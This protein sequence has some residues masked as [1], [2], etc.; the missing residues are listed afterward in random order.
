M[1]SIAFIC[2]SPE[3]SIK[4]FTFK[5]HI[6]LIIYYHYFLV[7]NNI[8]GFLFYY[9]KMD[10]FILLLNKFLSKVNELMKAFEND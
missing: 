9:D 5:Y 10:I 1:A 4:K 2:T 3:L 8:L 6:I 7:Y